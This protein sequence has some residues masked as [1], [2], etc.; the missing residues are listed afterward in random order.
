MGAV[1]QKLSLVHQVLSLIAVLLTVT[2]LVFPAS[3]SAKPVQIVKVKQERYS[4]NRLCHYTYQYPQLKGL[5][6][7]KVERK[8]NTFLKQ[9]VIGIYASLGEP[10]LSVDQEV[11]ECG[12]KA[13]ETKEALKRRGEA[14]ELSV[15]DGLYFRKVYY[16]IKINKLDLLSIYIYAFDD[17]H[18]YHP[19]GF[20]YPL[21]INIRNGK[22]Y[23]Y[24][25]LFKSRSKYQ[26]KINDLIYDELKNIQGESVAEEF[27]DEAQQSK[28]N[29]LISHDGLV[30]YDLFERYVD[31]AI[32]PVLRPSVLIKAGI[33][34][35]E[36]PLRV[37]LKSVIARSGGK[38]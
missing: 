17:S 15:F 25:D 11:E 31:Q 22:I 33:I 6:N 14:D 3:V 24:S 34:N 26:S 12:R 10:V 28:Y 1:W 21:A 16:D 18:G 2:L 38:Y 27:R 19:D 13:L 29:V 32:V 5:S 30:I 4:K 23:K 20:N 36:G 35:P 37:F 9:Q 8:L 7:K